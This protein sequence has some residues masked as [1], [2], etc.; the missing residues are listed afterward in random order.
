MVIYSLSFRVR[1]DCEIVHEIHD[2]KIPSRLCF[3]GL[4]VIGVADKRINISS[5]AI[6]GIAVAAIL[7]I[8]II[9]DFLCCV[10]VNL[11]IFS[12][13]C[14]KPKRSPSDLDEEKFG[15]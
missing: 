5:I 14:R 9:I 2:F 10:T 4:D 12:M 8:L 6:V 11:G 1:V 7:L 15:R 13:L 3:A